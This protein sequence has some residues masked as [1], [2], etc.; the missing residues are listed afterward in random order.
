MNGIETTPDVLKKVEAFIHYTYKKSEGNLMV[1]DI[2]GIENVL[3]DLEVATEDIID[4][5]NEFLFCLGNL[6]TNAIQVFLGDHECNAYCEA[7]NVPEKKKNSQQ[8]QMSLRRLQDVLKRSQ[9]LTTKQ[10]VVTTSGKRRRVYDVLKTSD[11][12]CLEDVN[13]RCL[14]YDVFRTSGLT[15][16]EDV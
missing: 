16:P 7:V 14:I 6:S 8:T 1:L 4:I 11:L 13:L 10:N 3:C 15:R 2:Q 5:E 9:C 12:Y